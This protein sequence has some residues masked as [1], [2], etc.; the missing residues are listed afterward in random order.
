MLVSRRS[1]GVASKVNL[2]IPLHVGDE[3]RKRRRGDD[4]LW[5]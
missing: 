5:L 3:D 4:P 2:G 1:A